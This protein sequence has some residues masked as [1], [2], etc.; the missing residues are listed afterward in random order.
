[1]VILGALVIDY[2]GIAYTHRE[3]I[4]DRRPTYAT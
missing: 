2:Q 1:M 3:R 4:L